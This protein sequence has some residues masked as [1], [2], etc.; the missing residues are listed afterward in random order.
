[1]KNF[2]LIFIV[3][4]VGFS[5]NW[6]FTHKYDTDEE[7]LV[8]L[9]AW[10]DIH[11]LPEWNAD[12]TTRVIGNPLSRELVV[13][14]KGT[15]TQIDTWLQTE[16]ALKKAEIK[17]ISDTQTKYILKPQNEAK[18]AEVLIDHSLNTVVIRATV[19]KRKTL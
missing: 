11:Q 9:L 5:M 10:T 18:Y 2:I 14:F 7:V 3:I 13:T 19:A 12:R 15:G 4:A 1:M 16:P 6:L 17:K 8:A